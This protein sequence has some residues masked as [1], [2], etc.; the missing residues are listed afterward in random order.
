MANP[1]PRHVRDLQWW[2]ALAAVP[3]AA[4][5]AGLTL[6]V[7]S[8]ATSRVDA[9][10]HT[11]AVTHRTGL[12][13]LVVFGLT[14]LGSSVV[15]VPLLL[16]GTA[17]LIARRRLRAAVYLWVTYLGGVVLYQVAKQVVNRPRPPAAELIG[18]AGG[19]AYPSGHSTQAITVWGMLAVVLLAGRSG[20][21]RAALLSA[22]AAVVALVGASRIYLGAHWLTDVLG[23]YALGGAWLALVLALYLRRGTDLTAPPRGA[24]ER[25]PRNRTDAPDANHLV[26]LPPRPP[27]APGELAA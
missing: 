1:V 11:F 13:D 23:G 8:G 26:R 12:L 5:F 16:A 10:V 6:A 3:C 22:A 25:A 20:R 15:L 18:P 17:I 21:V 4:T 14:W 2:T 24:A 19:M 9:R 27:D 7:S